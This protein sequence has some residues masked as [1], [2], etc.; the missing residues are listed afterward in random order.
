[1]SQSPKELT[2][3]ES[4]Q[5]FFGAELRR[6]RELRGLSQQTLGQQVNFDASLIGKVEKAERM[7][8]RALAEAC[9]RA[10]ETDGALARLWPLVER[11]R[12]QAAAASAPDQTV[13]P[14]WLA[15]GMASPDL[16]VA[17]V[18]TGEGRVVLMA[19][20]RRALLRSS[21]AAAVLPF[22]ATGVEWP[23]LARAL[24]APQR[25][26]AEIVDYLQRVLGE[27]STADRMLGPH[28][29]IDAV[30]AQMRVIGQLRSGARGEVRNELLTVEVRYAAFAGWLHQDMGNAHAATYWYD[31]AMEWAQQAGNDVMVSYVLRRKSQ[32]ARDECDADRAISLAQAAQRDPARLTSRACGVAAQ[33][34]AQGHALADDEVACHRKFDEALEL[35]ALAERNGDRGPG[36][37]VNEVYIEL[38]RANAWTELGHPQRGIDLFERELPKFPAVRQRDYGVCLARLAR[39]HAAN[40]DPEQAVTVGHQALGIRRETGSALISTELQRLDTML[41]DYG[42][43]PAVGEFHDALAACPLVPR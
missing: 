17:P 39:A 31:R 35:V 5:H 3:Y 23:R 29:V 15:P 2:P 41:A 19:I 37:G 1:M 25:V 16:V 12:E 18:L 20:D 34:E 6:W 24:Q 9:D 43:L 13:D 32:Q 14:L 30:A 26:D 27:Y 42:D 38:Q 11:E 22:G 4:V 40:R 21:G 33:Q 10:L 36:R 7:P 28:S 8:S